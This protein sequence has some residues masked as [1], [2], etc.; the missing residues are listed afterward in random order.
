MR[1]YGY[2]LLMFVCGLILAGCFMPESTLTESDQSEKVGAIQTR[3]V[4][5]RVGQVSATV[6]TMDAETNASD[7]TAGQPS[8]A[9]DS[10]MI[11][12]PTAAQQELLA[13]LQS[14]GEAPELL[15]EVWLNSEPLKLA[16]LRGKVVLVEFWTY[17]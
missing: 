17:G 16:D 11:V 5:A 12:G 13:K 7:G 4:E 1:R 3:V 2:A 10:A 15:N 8:A 14:Q 9:G 6:E